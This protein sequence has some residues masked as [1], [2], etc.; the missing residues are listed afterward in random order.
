[1]SPVELAILQAVTERVDHAI[2]EGHKDGL[3]GLRESERELVMAMSTVIPDEN[4]EKPYRA[5]ADTL[6]DLRRAIEAELILEGT[7][8][9]DP[10]LLLLL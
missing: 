8:G 7:P 1:M 9:E 6:E 4:S 10:K 3:A 5:A 2:R